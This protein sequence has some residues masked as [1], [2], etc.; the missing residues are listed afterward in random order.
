M[1]ACPVNGANRAESTETISRPGAEAHSIHG[2]LRHGSEFAFKFGAAWRTIN[3]KQA[4]KNETV[5]NANCV[6]TPRHS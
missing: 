2:R 1:P 3:V 4:K 5:R 6:D